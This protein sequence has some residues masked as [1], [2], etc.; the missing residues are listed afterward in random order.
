MKK[1]ILFTA[2]VSSLVAASYLAVGNYFYEYALKTKRKQ[3]VEE[4]D[5]VEKDDLNE[6]DLA[7]MIFLKEHPPVEKYLVSNDKR[8]LK[9]H[10]SLYSQASNTRKWVIVVHGYTS[11][12]REMAQWTRGFFDKGFNVL[13]PDLRGHG[14]SEGD[15]IGM[16]W[17]DR[18]DILNWV[19]AIIAENPDAEIIL[20]GV[21]MGGATVM[22]V[23]GEDLPNNV[24]VIVEDC[25]YTSARSVLSYQLKEQFNLPEF[26]AIQAVN[27]VARIRAG[28]N[29]FE[30]SAVNQLAN[31]KVPILFIH[32]EEDTFV[33]YQ[34][35]DDLYAATKSEKEKLTISGAGHAEAV[36]VNPELYWSTI[37]KFAGRFM[38][39]KELDATR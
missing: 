28:Y 39:F 10:G 2:A 15:Y 5:P 9:L 31:A 16:G 22:M 26:P 25:G 20:F 19:D 18:M 34:M 3:M 36:N 21:S 12:N 32:G 30:A 7:N 23:A 24:K 17:H 38:D 6:M 35:I 4:N 1:R 14:I 33:P 27:T 37:W 11:H 29:L 8:A 13:T